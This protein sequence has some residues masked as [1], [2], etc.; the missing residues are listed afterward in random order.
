[1]RRFLLIFLSLGALVALFLVYLRLQPQFGGM[2]QK[3]QPTTDFGRGEAPIINPQTGIQPG[4]G[5][6]AVQYDR[7]TGRR[8]YQFKSDFFDNQPDGSVKVTRPVIEIFLS[9]GQILQINGVDGIV[10]LPPGA[11]GEPLSGGGS[12]QMP[13]SGSLRNVTAKLYPSAAA[14]RDGANEMTMTMSNGRFDNDTFRLYTQEY[15]DA[16]GNV[17]HADQVPVQVTSKDYE[18]E[19][20]GLVLYWN[21]LNKKL[22]SLEIAH[23]KKL[24][25]YDP[26]SA[27][28]GGP[29]A[30]PVTSSTQA[31]PP[32]AP[33]VVQ[34]VPASPPP[35]PAAPTPTAQTPGETRQRYTFTL[36]NNVR[37]V[38]NNELV[39][40]AP[41]K[42]DVDFTLKSDSSEAAAS[43]APS[44]APSTAPPSTLPAD[45]NPAP[46]PGTEPPTTRPVSPMYVYW[47]GKL[48]VLPTDEAVAEPLADGKAIVHMEGSTVHVHQKDAGGLDTDI[49]CKSLKY[50][51]GDGGVYLQ[52]STDAPVVM[53]QKRADGIENT[54]RAPTVDFSRATN[55]ALLSGPGEAALPDPNQPSNVLDARWGKNCTVQLYPT[56]GGQMQISSA[57]LVGDVKVTHPKFKL[58]AR[59]DVT[60][61]FDRLTGAERS[62][63]PPLRQVIATGN[64]DSFIPEA[65]GKHR[66]ISGQYLE[67]LR[68][69]GPDGKLYAK[70]IKC[71]GDAIAGEDQQQIQAG[72][73]LIS[74]LPAPKKAATGASDDMGQVALDHLVATQDVRVS[75]KDGSFAAAP[76][77]DVQMVD[78]HSHITLTGS[79]AHPAEVDDK[80]TRLTGPEIHFSPDDQLAS[81]IGPGTLDAQQQPADGKGPPR[82]LHVNWS[83]SAVLDGAQNR[84]LV[85]GN[86]HADSHAPGSTDDSS[87]SDEILVTLADAPHADTSPATS[88][89]AADSAVSS[90]VQLNFMKNKQVRGLSLLSAKHA[91][92]ESV[93]RDAGGNIVRL[94]A[95]RSKRIDYDVVAKRAEVNGPGEMLADQPTT[96]PIASTADQPALG[97]SG[98]T[99][100]SWKKRFFYD[101]ATRMAQFDGSID[102]LHTEIGTNTPS[103][104]LVCDQVKVELESAAASPTPDAHSGQLHLRKVFALGNVEV[105]T[106]DNTVKNCATME[107]DPATSILT[108]RAAPD[109]QISIIDNKTAKVESF[110][111]ARINLKTNTIEK[112][113]NFNAQ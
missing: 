98:K 103:V 55:Y 20:S 39:A 38:Q 67:L 51:T 35:P 43:S 4:S 84:I 94:T 53:L 60:L 79:T 8:A 47:T 3:Q 82:P 99:L 106:T 89:P 46:A 44:A 93:L 90:T 74:L 78:G 91:L 95:L 14:L 109:G 66:E 26:Q 73:L 58:S 15:V 113:N 19:G 42:L 40:S 24:T 1:M 81:I 70:T 85:K 88:A 64:A 12:N 36:L 50:K 6:W 41:D 7:N 68:E 77:L 80:T 65:G 87:A 18:F 11:G 69:P 13:T 9:N 10:S 96:R 110:D 30:A 32:A 72:H 22:K 61:N 101:E 76:S 107:F 29:E 86:T 104:H 2:L 17:V 100:I 31:A 21:D 45:G 5:L 57:D 92:V 34:P 111:V 108:C 83:D 49:F 48:I 56:H 25:I 112:L 33:V 102:V 27:G 63:S 52:G 71:D 105:V 23:G 16:Q 62:S 97:D 28:L 37:V 54:V 75:G 59:D